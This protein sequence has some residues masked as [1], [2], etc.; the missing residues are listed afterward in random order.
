MQFLIARL[1]FAVKN[2]LPRYRY[3][4]P[5][6][7]SFNAI[8]SAAKQLSSK[9][10]IFMNYSPSCVSEGDCLDSLGMMYKRTTLCSLSHPDFPLSSARQGGIC[11]GR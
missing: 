9:L 8:I 11:Q 5:L 10:I 1:L 3:S 6:T 4:Y 2:Q 7:C